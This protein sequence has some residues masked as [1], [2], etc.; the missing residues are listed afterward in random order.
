MI[1]IEKLK[2]LIVEALMPLKPDKIILFGSYAYGV[3]NEDS[4]LDI[5]VVEKDYENK[6]KEK[7]KIRKLLKH[8]NHPKDILNPKSEEF[9]FY[10]HEINSV[11]YDAD[12]K[13]VCLW[14]KNS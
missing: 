4:D 5:C 8:I 7:E 6:W 14:Q 10:R 11:Y 13:G 1:D 3:P 12:K 9:E 2:P